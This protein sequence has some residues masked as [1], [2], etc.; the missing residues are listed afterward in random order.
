M[1]ASI[2]ANKDNKASRALLKSSFPWQITVFSLTTVALFALGG[3]M[4]LHYLGLP[5]DYDGYD[6]G[7]YWQSLR[8]MSAGHTLY[9]QVFYAQPPFFLL[10]TFPIYTLLGQTLW[11]A[12]LSIALISL[13]GLVGALLLGK[14]LSGRVGAIAALLLLVTDPLYL[15]Q[16][17]SIQAEAP[18]T[19]LALLAVGTAYLWW[20]SPD[21]LAGLCYA[22]LTGIALSL[23][24]LSKLLDISVLIPVGLLMCAH[25]WR[26]ARRQPGSR[27]AGTRS[28]LAGSAAF[29]ITTLLVVLPFVG[30]WPQVWQDVVTFHT[31]AGSALKSTQSNNISMLQPLLFSFIGLTALSGISIALLKKD[32]RVLPLLAWFLASLLLLWRQT[33]LFHHHLVALVPPLLALTVIGIGPLS[34]GK[35]QRQRSLVLL[36]SASALSLLLLLGLLAVNYQRVQPYYSALQQQNTSNLQQTQVV[37]DL[38]RATR[39]GQLVVTDAQFL[40][41]LADRNTPAA[42][43]DTS[44]VRLK[45]QYVTQ[46]QL[47]QESDRSQV[48]AVLF[49]TGRLESTPRSRFYRWVTQHFRLSHDYGNGKQLWVR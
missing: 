15:A 30:A 31:D 21:G 41:G 9:Q 13:L 43:V 8:A 47:I 42:L 17:Q 40:A 26:L 23:G 4:R 46:S 14:A 25:L 36:N 27:L 6:E 12:R 35:Q 44:M 32:W 18:A 11:S 20:N 7:V 39:P 10:F 5:F 48:H 3:W 28:L 22:L 37:R 24:I 34:W 38:Q 1:A 2:V 45:A 49:Y 16:S 29:L 19:A 33:P